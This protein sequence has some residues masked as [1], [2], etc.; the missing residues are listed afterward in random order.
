MKFKILFLV[1]FAILVRAEPILFLQEESVIPADYKTSN[2]AKLE[3]DKNSEDD[4]SHYKIY[5]IFRFLNDSLKVVTPDTTYI[6]NLSN[7]WPDGIFYSE[8]TFYVTAWDYSSN[9][10]GKSNTVVRL[11]SKNPSIMGDYNQDGRVLIGDIMDQMAIIGKLYG[12]LNFWG[13][14]DTDGDGRVLIGDIMITATNI[15]RTLK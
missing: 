9:E 10:S 1:I 6:I 13:T 12:D 8:V 3:W 4:L 7:Y 11:F 15:G 14:A 2:R 5:G